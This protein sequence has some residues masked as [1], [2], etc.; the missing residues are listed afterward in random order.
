MS[1]SKIVCGVVGLVSCSLAAGCSTSSSGTPT[2]IDF[3]SSGQAGSAPVSGELFA[4]ENVKSSHTAPVVG[5]TLL[6]TADGKQFVAADP[7]RDAVFL[8]DVASHAVRQVD[9]A[10]G[11]EPGR[12]IEGPPGYVYVAARR[13]GEVLTI[14]L[15]SATVIAKRAVCASPRGMAY[16]A[17]TAS[18]YV[19]CRS[20]Q[21]V[22]LASADFSVKRSLTVA[23]DLRDVIVR[24]HDLVLTRF[25]NAEVLVVAED[26]TTSRRA[27]PAASLNCGSGTATVAFR[28]LDAGD[29]TIALAH[30]VSSE[31]PVAEQSGAY[32]GIGCGGLVSRVLTIV[33][34][35][36]PS[37]GDGLSPGAPVGTAPMTF[38]SSRLT[39]AG[40]LDIAI[41]HTNQRVAT[42]AL[43]N[44]LEAN[45]IVPTS[46]PPG[47]NLWLSPWIN[48]PADFQFDPSVVGVVVPGQP[49]AVAFDTGGSYVVQSREPATL[50]LE[51]GTHIP[52]STESHADAGHR[53]F[54]MNSGIGVA[55]SSCH[56]EGG[57]DGHT[58]HLPE[59]LRRTMPLEGGVMERAPFHWDG[60]L[61]DMTALVNLVMVKR[62]SL[63]AVPSAAQIGTLGSF[64]EQLPEL[65]PA[66]NLDPA[67][68]ARGKAQ[69]ER[70]DVAC[71]SCH[72]GPQY[73]NNQLV[74]V[75][76][77]GRFVTP[78]LL[79]VGL[80]PA[81]FHDGCA[82]SIEQRFGACGGLAHGHPEL[83]SADEQSDLV[84]FMRSL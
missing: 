22:T 42:I 28:A 50:E 80:R 29:G 5:G 36:Q 82:K 20:G 16:D 25:M 83:L 43:D 35:D 3:G 49:V 23:S 6:A 18:L 52:L 41:D 21:L 74:D 48:L 70:A 12:V 53:M 2:P 30:Q 67:A 27:A 65:P 47:A 14:D 15:S 60:S 66:D 64:L 46:G 34:P 37:R 1:V 81:L 31:E 44:S 40:P 77:G 19:A 71:A 61:P 76:T 8:V 79:G 58:W 69:F 56:P 10:A 26:G 11:S 39:S 55:C 45:L 68:V 75:G 57:D 51:N 38:R 9:L 17:K 59:G 63:A 72:S 78:T 32:G 62:M 24:E 54:F 73:T 33:N 84:A 7:D 13:S 4:G